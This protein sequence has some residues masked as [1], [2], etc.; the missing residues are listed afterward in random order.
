MASS[1][2]EALGELVGL[3]AA[4][5][6]GP[7]DAPALGGVQRDV[8]ALGRSLSQ[9]GQELSEESGYHAGNLF[10]A[11]K[12]PLERV[13]G[14]AGLAKMV[15]GTVFEGLGQAG[16]GAGAAMG[17]AANL[18]ENEARRL[19][20]V[21]GKEGPAADPQALSL[22]KGYE[23]Y[24]KDVPLAGQLAFE[25]GAT[26]PLGAAA[27]SNLTS[28]VLGAGG[29][30]SLRQFL[31]ELESATGQIPLKALTAPFGAAKRAAQA[32]GVGVADRQSIAR[33]AVDT[34]RQTLERA[35]AALRA[36]G[37]SQSDEEIARVLTSAQAGDQAASETLSA[38]SRAVDEFLSPKQQKALPAGAGAVPI[39]PPTGVV[40]ADDL[41]ETT[42]ALR[43][44]VAA[45]G[46][47]PT[48]TAVP[49]PPQAAPIIKAPVAP[50][51]APAT[52][53]PPAAPPSPA[54]PLSAQ[55]RKTSEILREYLASLGPQR[56]GVFDEP[57]PAAP[58]LTAAAPIP[59]V[60][61]APPALGEAPARAARTGRPRLAAEQK[62]AEVERLAAEA[63]ALVEEARAAPDAARL[64]FLNELVAK[65]SEAQ[66]V[67]L[68]Y[69][70]ALPDDIK[71]LRAT[72][73]GRGRKARVAGA[74]ALYGKLFGYG[75][76]VAA[77]VQPAELTAQQERAQQLGSLYQD[78]EFR[79]AIGRPSI[80]VPEGE[81]YR[82]FVAG[83]DNA[84]TPAQRELSGLRDQLD[85]AI[86]DA[87]ARYFSPEGLGIPSREEI[88]RLERAT[89]DAAQRVAAEGGYTLRDVKALNE[90][91]SAQRAARSG[92]TDAVKDPTAQALVPEAEVVLSGALARADE[93]G[94]TPKIRALTEGG[95]TQPQITKRLRAEDPK[96]ADMTELDR[97]VTYVRDATKRGLTPDP[98][99]IPLAQAELQA[100]KAQMGLNSQV[101][102]AQVAA[103]NAEAQVLPDLPAV[104]A[105]PTAE[106]VDAEKRLR[107][108]IQKAEF[109]P[110]YYDA[111]IKG[112]RQQFLT[113]MRDVLP[114]A[115]ARDA[116]RL[117]DIVAAN[118]RAAARGTGAALAGFA[119]DVQTDEQGNV[120]LSQ[121]GFDPAKA[122]IVLGL[123][124][125]QVKRLGEDL[126]AVVKT[127]AKYK[128]DGLPNNVNVLLPA[129]TLDQLA[130]LANGYADLAQKVLH[131]PLNLWRASSSSG[132]FLVANLQR[133]VPIKG[134]VP[135]VAEIARR[136]GA[137]AMTVVEFGQGR[138]PVSRIVL[139]DY[140]HAVS[141]RDAL[142]QT[143]RFELVGIEPNAGY[144]VGFRV[145]ALARVPKQTSPK[146]YPAAATAFRGEIAK[147]VDDTL[148]Q[149]N[150][151][152]LTVQTTQ[153]RVKT[154]E[155]EA[156]RE[157]ASQA[158]LPSRVGAPRAPTPPVAPRPAGPTSA[159]AVLDP[160]SAAT[161]QPAAQLA[162]PPVAQIDDTLRPFADAGVD[163]ARL[164]PAAER[165]AST[166]QA[167][168]SDTQAATAAL[169]E[170]NRLTGTSFKTI[171]D[172]LRDRAA[173]SRAAVFPD[174][175]PALDT[176]RT[177]RGRYGKDPLTRP[178]GELVD[179]LA[180]GA[181]ERRIEPTPLEKL[182]E[183]AGRNPVFR[184][185]GAVNRIYRPL[186]LMS[187]RFH[188]L[189]M[190]DI[191]FKSM[192]GEGIKAFRTDSTL[193]KML[194]AWEQT[195]NPARVAELSRSGLTG[196]L[197]STD[198]GIGLIRAPKVVVDG[199]GRNMELALQKVPLLRTLEQKN[200]ALTSYMEE[201]A[202]LSAYVQGKQR[203]MLEQLPTFARAV[204]ATAGPQAASQILDT[205]GLLGPKRLGELLG[206]IPQRRELI[207][208]WMRLLQAGDEAGAKLSTRINFNY[209]YQ[210]NLDSLLRGVLLFHVFST[211]NLVYYP[212][213]LASHPGVSAAIFS[214]ARGTE[215]DRTARGQTTR[216]VGASRGGD[217]STRLAETLFGPNAE[218][219]INPLGYLSGVGQLVPLA[220]QLARPDPQQTAL[221]TAIGGAGNVGF[222][223]APPLQVGLEVANNATS[224]ALLGTGQRGRGALPQ[225]AALNA[226]A[227]GVS[228]YPQDVDGPIKALLGGSASQDAAIRRRVAEMAVEAG[229]PGAY[230]AFM[231]DPN[232]PIYQQAAA[233]VAHATALRGLTG[234]V[235]GLQVQPISGGEKEI[236]QAQKDAGYPTE[237]FDPN[238]TPLARAARGGQQ[239]GATNAELEGLIQRDPRGTLQRFVVEVPAFRGFLQR[240]GLSP[241]A[242]NR[243]DPDALRALLRTYTFDPVN[244]GSTPTLSGRA[245]R[246]T[247]PAAD[248]LRQRTQGPSQEAQIVQRYLLASP[249]EKAALMADP[250]VAYVLTKALISGQRLR[251]AQP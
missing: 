234:Y 2:L 30:G 168:Q 116:E 236:R 222:G 39:A 108:L 188:V 158:N 86:E 132:D 190:T 209:R 230:D 215:E 160:S 76:E 81:V 52:V 34:D 221:G 109:P 7:L 69:R 207:G 161:A 59:P 92:L 178:R 97:L 115:A 11:G 135:K 137:E 36:A 49:A 205:Q 159:N 12:N 241:E 102:Q 147:L 218:I 83:V 24:Q 146:D 180:V 16:R 8:V 148:A 170:I 88:R 32:R 131:Q 226:V 216:M 9:R 117:W 122:A 87:Q 55:P 163:T 1:F 244:V 82:L 53:A 35:A 200:R 50:P 223:L 13:L 206:D 91:V 211:R 208:T 237:A 10:G 74:D 72:A 17:M 22:S 94:L 197:T 225:A 172:F 90:S 186:A 144:D 79:A 246:E 112:D 68:R 155:G 70:L 239:R 224:G 124:S 106:V 217:A 187:P 45:L 103:K 142:E 248:R 44:L 66:K 29:K 219:L 130:P 149:L 250:N 65:L 75:D 171:D 141:V 18:G 118:Q 60:E 165:L 25:I 121:D 228:G 162:A 57:I 5:R 140:E 143:G 177:V 80:P 240:Q 243:L 181:L 104:T 247:T 150:V 229:S 123:S 199:F 58:P 51:A 21:S 105:P 183:A 203:F 33:E 185:L 127:A 3:S 210:T 133:F 84:T 249:A 42:D 156:L 27:G 152:T 220:K 182:A 56:M 62:A 189:N 101:L 19:M 125:G 198:E 28:R 98:D 40:G 111:A 107:G 214:Y 153:A 47:P 23:R 167:V 48:G 41:P 212:Q 99:A 67:A 93:L 166:T 245:Y 154:L 179:Q 95:L 233:Q 213:I 139:R 151:P 174:Q 227:S 126:F 195:A 238:S 157:A 46:S 119:P 175:Q 134:L 31:S 204:E 194:N 89:L 114:P 145:I 129:R 78:P 38:W 251:P 100:S 242:A 54:A 113:L 26:L 15:P 37:V 169:A 232:S 61:L 14:A 202:R 110:E 85:Q 176:L 192:V 136:N 63:R 73:A 196:K 231:V 120:T 164:G 43:G 138:E 235:S 20:G 184:A 173:V 193:G 77:Q 128:R 4:Q 201:A 6:R 71:E 191:A 64:G 96:L